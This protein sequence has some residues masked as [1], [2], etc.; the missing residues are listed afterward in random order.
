MITPSLSPPLQPPTLHRT[1]QNPP[2]RRLNSVYSLRY[3]IADIKYRLSVMHHQTPMELQGRCRSL[4]GQLEELV[5]HNEHWLSILPYGD[6]QATQ[7]ISKLRITI[8]DMMMRIG[9]LL[10]QMYDYRNTM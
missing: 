9:I 5:N 6:N 7:N 4:I 2:V 1:M 8:S 10:D 3:Y